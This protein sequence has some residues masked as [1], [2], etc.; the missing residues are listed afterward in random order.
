MK[1]TRLLLF[2]FVLFLGSGSVLAQGKVSFTGIIHDEANNQPIPFATVLAISNSTQSMVAGSTTLDDGSFAF[3]S[4][5]TDVSLE[6]S[7]IGYEI[8]VIQVFSAVNGTVDFG[9]LLLSASAEMLNEVDI[10]AEQSTFEFKLDKRV[11][12]V[13]KAFLAL[14]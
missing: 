5:S 2:V 7:F 8:K 4:D 13:G 1:T 11:F 14:V 6:L 3:V 10:V 12:N 9:V